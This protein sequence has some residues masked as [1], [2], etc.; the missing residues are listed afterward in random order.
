MDQ[1]YLPKPA[2][3]GWLSRTLPARQQHLRVRK[4]LKIQDLPKSL[5]TNKKFSPRSPKTG[6]APSLRGV[7]R[8]LFLGE[9]CSVRKWWYTPPGPEGS[10]KPGRPVVHLTKQR[11][12]KRPKR[13]RQVTNQPGDPATTFYGTFIIFEEIMQGVT[14]VF[15]VYCLYINPRPILI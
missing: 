13:G 15:M 14:F 11:R 4:L 12:E 9:G 6:P 10:N 7:G 5:S 2:V 3:H 8:R 1:L